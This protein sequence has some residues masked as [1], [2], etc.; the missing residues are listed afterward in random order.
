MRTVEKLSRKLARTLFHAMARNGPK[1]ERRQL[2]L[3][4]LVDAGSELFAMSVSV[5]RAHAL[6]D[7]TSRQTARYICRRGRQRVETL[8][9]DA[10]ASPDKE[11]YRLAKGM[12]DA[13]A[14]AGV[15]KAP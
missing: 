6:G 7:E 8:F 13:P 12:L 15:P 9:A 2:L 11:A 3:G 5:A 14:Q 4:R 1:L 10:G